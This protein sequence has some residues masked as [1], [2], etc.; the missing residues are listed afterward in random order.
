[1][2]IKPLNWVKMESQFSTGWYAKIEGSAIGYY[3]WVERETGK[4]K[5]SLLDRQHKYF[6]SVDEAKNWCQKDFEKIIEN[7]IET[8]KQNP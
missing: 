6:N 3:I 2:K 1:M 7:F 4:T 5:A 8:K